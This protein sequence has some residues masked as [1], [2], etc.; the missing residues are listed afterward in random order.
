MSKPD[1]GERVQY[2]VT[3]SD[4]VLVEVVRVTF[5]DKIDI[6]LADGTIITDVRRVITVDDARVPP[7]A[8]RFVR[9][10]DGY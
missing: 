5:W 1:V 2:F 4:S 8:G 7:I 6:R 3:E 10:A 9:V